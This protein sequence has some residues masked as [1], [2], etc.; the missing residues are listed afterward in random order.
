[1]T[2]RAAHLRV[3]RLF[4]TLLLHEEATAA[5]D[6]T[7]HDE[8]S[9]WI[10]TSPY[11]ST[12]A[13]PSN[14][15]NDTTDN[16]EPEIS[17]LWENA[18]R[19]ETKSIRDAVQVYSHLPNGINVLDDKWALAR[20]MP[21]NCNDND[22]ALATLESHCFRGSEG[23]V[24]F[25]KRVGLLLSTDEHNDANNDEHAE[26]VQYQFQD[27]MQHNSQQQQL[28]PP[29]KNLWVIKDAMSNGAGGIW[30]VDP[31]NA[32]EF[33]DEQQSVLHPGTRIT[34]F[35]SHAAPPLAAPPTLSGPAIPLDRDGQH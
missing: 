16:I 21:S 32:H 26:A 34:P 13:T 30:I 8:Q 28:P 20:L 4:E 3:A 18:P 25:A 7:T 15:T 19:Y 24:T 6:H 5:D 17:F 31:F 11:T 9:R 14:T 1:M 35:A 22:E 23:F 2:G 29:P 10:D 12:A 33:T 27:L